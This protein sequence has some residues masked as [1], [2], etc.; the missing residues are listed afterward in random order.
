M[1]EW[2]PEQRRAIETLDRPFALIAGAG[3]G[4]T[5]VL[6]ERY[7]RL[8]ARGLRPHEILTVT[9]T[10]EAAAEL[11]R[12]IADRLRREESSGERLI[13]EV[14]TASTIGTI[15]A[16][17]YQVLDQFGGLMGLYPVEGIVDSFVAAVA[18]DREYDRWVESLPA[19]R[20]ESLLGKFSRR[21]LRRIA[22]ELWGDHRATPDG[23]SPEG[24]ELW[25]ACLPLWNRLDDVLL[26]RGLYTFSDLETLTARVLQD[27]PEA[28]EKLSGRI[29]ALLIDEFQDTSPLQW[30]I[31]R[32]AVGGD[33]NRIFVVGDPKQSIYGFRAADVRV[34]LDT[35]E[36]F[37]KAGGEIGQL[38]QNF[39]S[40][41]SLLGSLNSLSAPL[42]ENT[43]V[44]FAAMVPGRAAGE[45][46]PRVQIL[47]TENVEAEPRQVALQVQTLLLQGERPEDIALLFRVSDRI[48]RYRDALA[49]LGIAAALKQTQPLFQNYDVLDL[50]HGLEALADP[51]NDFA[52]GAFLASPQYAN[53]SPT[54]LLAVQRQTG[55][56]LY[57]KLVASHLAPAFVA[58]IERGPGT[59]GE[60]LSA[61]FQIS[62]RLPDRPDGAFGLVAALLP[63]SL[64]LFEAVE[65]IQRWRRGDLRVSGGTEARGVRLMTVHG[66]K[67]LEFRHVFLVD[68][69]RLSPR[70][71]PPVRKDEAGFGVRWR[72]RG[73]AVEDE[74]YQR[75]S[76]S[77]KDREMEESKRI[78]Y[79]ALTRAKETLTLGLPRVGAKVPKNTWAEWLEPKV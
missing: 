30:G 54:E 45:I 49:D 77:S 41:P 14:E 43:A 71:A 22:R 6:V 15:H 50:V 17:C 51:F 40:E 56:T 16:F 63:S 28:V 52:L 66:A 5:T 23:L 32:Q 7:R 1:A 34:F 37:E 8:L 26:A 73:E 62:G 55:E 38:S 69:L 72:K 4:K 61:L 2:T 9:F 3:S 25:E 31:L 68:T 48:G 64:P 44:P 11:K 76:E 78:L 70:S 33:L 19:E 21:D 36:A 12:R 42:F 58:A 59:V 74:R 27:A 57:E 35:A 29:K 10:Q 60:A 79:V 65:R 47:R 75:I 67:G 46:V 39:R 53:L 13:R 24:S 18:F 20:F